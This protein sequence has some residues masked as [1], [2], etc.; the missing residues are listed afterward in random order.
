M[1]ISYK[2]LGIVPTALSLLSF[3]T[4]LF[5]QTDQIQ[6]ARFQD[7]STLSQK[8]HIVEIAPELYSVVYKEPDVMREKGIM[9]G[10]S[11]SYA[12][13]NDGMFKIEGRYFY[14]NVDYENSGKIDNI[15]DYGFEIRLL[16]GYDF[17]PTNTLTITPSIGFGYRYLKDDMGGRISSIGA[18]GYSRE[19]NY[20]YSPIAIEAVQVI[21][22]R[23]S[24]G[25]M[26]E[27]DYLWGGVQQTN[28]KDVDPRLNNLR[29]D[30]NSGYG[31]RASLVVKRQTGWGSLA[32]EPFIRYW[33]I[34]NSVEQIITQSGTP[35]AIGWEPTNNTTE[36]GLRLGI[37]F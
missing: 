18:M 25:A 34:E 14:G 36:I 1:K 37:G 17:K 28:L 24:V 11:A 5:A 30:Q 2:I 20:Y 12:Y 16:G 32:I 3:G 7:G 4:P 15:K 10:I 29:N 6:K 27:Y 19:A 35:V 21:N 8:T 33:R 26:L 22:D 9:G 23:W 13:H 31:L